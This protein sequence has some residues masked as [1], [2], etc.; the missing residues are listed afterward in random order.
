M[1]TEQ[2]IPC[3]YGLNEKGLP[4]SWWKAIKDTVTVCCSN[5]HQL[6]IHK[7]QIPEDG[8]K[9]PYLCAEASCNHLGES[10]KGGVRLEGYKQHLAIE[11]KKAQKKLEPPVE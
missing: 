5:G 8:I 4:G 6:T 11:L 1:E 3:L 2:S 7:D 9:S 10:F